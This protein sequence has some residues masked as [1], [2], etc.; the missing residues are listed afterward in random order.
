MDQRHERKTE[1]YTMSRRKHRRKPLNLGLGKDM[2]PKVQY[3]KDQIDLW[4]PPK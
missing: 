1:N 2:T 4:T 3:L